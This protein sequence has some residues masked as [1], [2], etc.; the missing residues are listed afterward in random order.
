MK[1]LKLFEELKDESILQ[2]AKDILLEF[3]DMGNV[4]KVD[5]CDSRYEDEVVITGN[6]ISWVKS[7]TSAAILIFI[8]NETGN[9]DVDTFIRLFSY[10]KERGFICNI[11]RCGKARKAGCDELYNLY[12]LQH[13]K[14]FNLDKEIDV[15]NSYLGLELVFHKMKSS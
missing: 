11:V 4:V 9:L 12:I 13:A 5:W 15:I 6:L 2:D 10:M 14:D 7:L 8:K 3:S 1:Y